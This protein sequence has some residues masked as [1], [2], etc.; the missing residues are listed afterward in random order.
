MGIR[1]YCPN[2]HKLNVKA[3]QAGRKGICPYCGAK[4]QIP[5][6]S[7]RKSSKGAGPAGQRRGAG[8][9]AGPTAAGFAP[10]PPQGGSGV[11]LSQPGGFIGVESPV[12]ASEPSQAVIPHEAAPADLAAS[13]QGGASGGYGA[14]AGYA[15]APAAPS[16]P[17]APSAPIGSTPSVS[18]PRDPLS[19]GGDVV[20]YVRPPSGGQFGPAAP[21]I[22]RSWIEQGRV[23]PDSL[24]WRE[25]W[26]DW[27][28]AGGVFPQLGAGQQASP[29]RQFEHALA[30]AEQTA[31]PTA[32][33]VRSRRQSQTVQM[34]IVVALVLAVIVLFGVFLW[35][36]IRED[37]A[38]PENAR[39]SAPAAAGLLET[40]ALAAAPVS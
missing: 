7:T 19:E 9:Q 16:Q 27:Q 39:A 2:G 36:L 38:P 30:P 17:A 12:Q 29:F 5:T 10:G 14:T 3:F 11:A 25:G 37:K 40:A 6:H 32:Q 26:R 8:V 22:M 35:V 24:V 18:V 34:A 23:S 31:S 15:S 4:I 33:R 13:P 1:F 20:W 21:D 28:E